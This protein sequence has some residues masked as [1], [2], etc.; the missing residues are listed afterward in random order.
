MKKFIIAIC[1]SSGKAEGIAEVPCV[2]VEHLTDVQLTGFDP[3]EVENLFNQQD[4]VEDDNFD[5]AA[6]LERP[7]VTRPGDL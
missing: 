4:A 2:F 5:V 3:A 6:E 1:K 7:A